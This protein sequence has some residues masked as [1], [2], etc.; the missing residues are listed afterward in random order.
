MRYQ[1]AHIIP[2]FYKA[3]TAYWKT[4]LGDKSFLSLDKT[5]DLFF[6]D[7]VNYIYAHDNLHLEVA[8]PRKP[9]Y[10]SV[11][12]EGSEV[13]I[14]KSKFNK[15]SYLSQLVMF[16]EEIQTI[17]L[18]R[19]ILN[20]YW[21]EKELTIAQ[22]HSLAVQ[23]TI[24]N[25]TKNWACDFIIQNLHHFNT[26]N[27]FTYHKVINKLLNNKQKEKYM[28]NTNVVE[29]LDSALAELKL[30]FPDYVDDLDNF[31]F[32]CTEGDLYPKE[33]EKFLEYTHLDQEGGGEGGAEDCYGVFRLGDRIF[34]AHYS[35]QSYNGHDYDDIQETVRE[36]KPVEKTVTVYE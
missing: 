14:S 20:P 33:L 5:K 13:L 24:T 15:L 26:P 31:I 16:E 2:S 1:G 4:E 12:K 6:Q 10:Q 25:L 32:Q 29:F 34:K 9:M 8:Y 36:V 17:A 21:L 11:L 27:Y 18:E 35:Y 30:N 19:W 3:L 23:K 22:A 28:T 7:H